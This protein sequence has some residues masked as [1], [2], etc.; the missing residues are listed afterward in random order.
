RI[1]SG[2]PRRTGALQPG[3]GIAA[4]NHARRL[5]PAAAGADAAG[6]A[7]HP[8]HLCRGLFRGLRPGRET[9]CGAEHGRTGLRQRGAEA[10]PST[11]SA[12]PHQQ[13][14]LHRQAAVPQRLPDAA[15]PGAHQRRRAGTG[16]T[17]AGAGAAAAGTETTAG[18]D[19]RYRPHRSRPMQGI[20]DLPNLKVGTLGGGY[21]GTPVAALVPRNARAM[22]WARNGATV[23]EI[24]SRHS[25]E[26]YRPG[27]RL[28]ETLQAT[29][30]IGE[31]VAA[32]E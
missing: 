1:P 26:A 14:I 2:D 25:N 30:D 7:R 27:A 31:A 12:A 6:G 17:A 21:W 19:P 8:A 20:H 11:V 9:A 5:Y 16:R 4:R 29:A 22:L 32:S 15:A 24:T 3:L 18:S 28:P 13:R 10:G 23:Q